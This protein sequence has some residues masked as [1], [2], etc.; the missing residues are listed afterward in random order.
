MGAEHTWICAPLG[1]LPA[2]DKDS[3]PLPLLHEEPECRSPAGGRSWSNGDLPWIPWG[4][5]KGQERVLD[6]G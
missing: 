1:P 6:Q 3:F 2:P 5:T 4:E